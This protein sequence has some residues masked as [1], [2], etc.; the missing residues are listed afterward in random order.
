MRLRL[1]ISDTGG[2]RVVEL[3]ETPEDRP[4]VVGRGGIATV[5]VPIPSVSTRHCVLWLDGQ[6]WYVR[7]AGSRCGTFVNGEQ[8][9]G[10]M[11][12]AIQD[13]DV[14]TLGAWEGAP[15]LQVT[16]GGGAPPAAAPMTSTG[17]APEAEGVEQG[18]DED[19]EVPLEGV[20][21]PAVVQERRIY[22]PSSGKSGE[23]IVLY[24]ILAVILIAGG[25][26]FVVLQV[27]G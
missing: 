26:W 14:I 15:T 21:V 23:T 16:Y 13:G 17:L 22:V 24:F 19:V 9:V 8:V 12:M 7:D 4:V 6:T 1:G 20:T 10:T 5:V 27:S 2:G 25:T 11:A 3:E 18:L